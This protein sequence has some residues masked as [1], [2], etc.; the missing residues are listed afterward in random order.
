MG[1]GWSNW[2]NWSNCDR[3]CITA[4]GETG[5]RQRLREGDFAGGDPNNMNIR[6][7]LYETEQGACVETLPECP[8]KLY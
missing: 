5:T 6:Q 2:E 1:N 3:T 7:T 8:G 4:G